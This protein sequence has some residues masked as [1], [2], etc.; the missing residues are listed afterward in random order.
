[1]NLLFSRAFSYILSDYSGFWLVKT[2]CIWILR[3]GGRENF[4]HCDVCDVCLSISMKDNHKV[5]DFTHFISD[6]IDTK[7]CYKYFCLSFW[8]IDSVA[9]VT[10][11]AVFSFLT[12]YWEI[13]PLKLSGVSGGSS[14]IQ[15]CS[16]YS[17]LWSSNSLVR[18]IIHSIFCW[19]IDSK[20]SLF[21]GNFVFLFPNRCKP[22]KFLNHCLP[23]HRKKPL[24]YQCSFSSFV[25]QFPT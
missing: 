17:T 12:V 6:H 18:V 1:M 9:S 5:R 21:K 16:P 23:K 13:V 25:F 14:H 2:F 10:W 20:L 22:D 15:N 3:V 8:F 19:S 7:P 4:Y 24:D 11:S